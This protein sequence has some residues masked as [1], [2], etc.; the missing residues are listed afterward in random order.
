MLITAVGQLE[1]ILR[2]Q[3]CFTVYLTARHCTLP[4]LTA[5]NILHYVGMD[6]NIVHYSVHTAQ[7]N[8]NPYALYYTALQRLLYIMLYVVL[9]ISVC[10]TF[11]LV[12]FLSLPICCH[13]TLSLSL[14]LTHSLSLSLSLSLLLLSLSTSS[15]SLYLSLSPFLPPSLLQMLAQEYQYRE[16][17]NLLDA[18]KQLMTHFNK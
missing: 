3:D 1:V 18:V 6:Y 4:Y 17:A 11:S 5:P 2:C 16:A 10:L 14:S 15:L 9:F 12:P 7:F 8:A 13:L